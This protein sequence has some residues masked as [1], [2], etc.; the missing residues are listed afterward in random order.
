MSTYRRIQI[1]PYLSPCTNI[2]SKWIKDLNMNLATMNF[3]KEK[4]GSSIEHMDKGDH[5]VNIIPVVHKL[6]SIINKVTS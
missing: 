2:N 3:I 1:D 5:F 4:V 6:K